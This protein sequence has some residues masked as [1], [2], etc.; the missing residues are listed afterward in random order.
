MPTNTTCFQR[1]TS[2][3]EMQEAQRTHNHTRVVTNQAYFAYRLSLYQLELAPGSR[4]LEPLRTRKLLTSEGC[5]ARDRR[6]PRYWLLSVA[7]G[8]CKPRLYAAEHADA[9]G[10]RG[11]CASGSGY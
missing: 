11:V 4:C 8:L 7:L 10:R 3:L 6:H 5:D 2:L 9:A 1:A